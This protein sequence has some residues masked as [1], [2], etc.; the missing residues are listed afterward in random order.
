MERVGG[1]WEI[2]E[3][4]CSTSQSPQWAVVP[5]EEEEEEVIRIY[6]IHTRYILVKDNNLLHKIMFTLT[7]FDSN[8]SSSG[9]PNEPIQCTSYIRVYFGIP[10]ALIYDIPW[11]SSFGW[12]DNGSLE[13]KHVSVSIILCNKLLCLTETCIWYELD[14]HIGMTTEKTYLFNC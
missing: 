7:C 13:S 3:G 6:L 4:H 10:N 11:I 9:Q 12:P 1:R 2:M 5:M 8:E 14:K